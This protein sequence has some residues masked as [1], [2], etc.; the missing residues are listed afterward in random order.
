MRYLNF[1]TIESC[2]RC[3]GFQDQKIPKHSLAGIFVHFVR[4]G[5]FLGL[6]MAACNDDDGVGLLLVM[7]NAIDVHNVG[8]NATSIL[9]PTSTRPDGEVKLILYFR[10]QLK[11]RGESESRAPLFIRA[12]QALPI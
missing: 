4:L 2:G 5:A 9:E 3:S 7:N 11:K 12:S 10:S 1:E 8:S 6:S